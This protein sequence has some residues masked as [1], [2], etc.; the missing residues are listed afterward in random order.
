M[1]KSKKIERMRRMLTVGVA[2]LASLVMLPFAKAVEKPDYRLDD[3]KPISFTINVAETGDYAISL[4]LNPTRKLDGTYSDYIIRVNG[5]KEYLI[6]GLR[7]GGWQTANLDDAYVL[8]NKGINEIELFSKTEDESP[9]LEYICYVKKNSR[10]YS[11]HLN[12]ENYRKLVEDIRSGADLELE[13]NNCD[14]PKMKPVNWHG[15][16]ERLPIVYS[17]FYQRKYEKG[18]TIN[19]TGVGDKQFYIDVF[20]IGK[21]WL[22]QPSPL[23]ENNG[24]NRISIGPP[25][26]GDSLVPMKYI[27]NIIDP[28]TTDETQG[29]NWQARSEKALNSN[30]QICSMRIDI[31]QT[32]IYMVKL[33]SVNRGE[34]SLV[35]LT[36]NGSYV[37]EDCITTYQGVDCKIFAGNEYLLFTHRANVQDDPMLFVEGA[38]ADRVVAWNDD[39]TDDKK[40]AV[41]IRGYDAL[42]DIAYKYR[43]S[44]VHVSNFSSANPQSYVDL[45]TGLYT[46]IHNS[47]RRIL[48]SMTD[49]NGETDLTLTIYQGEVTV[50]GKPGEEIN[51]SSIT[52][53][54]C[55]I[56]TISEN[57]ISKVNL[58]PGMYIV[59]RVKDGGI[60][61]A[62]K[63]IIK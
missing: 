56:L 20:Y 44:R 63:I 28:C 7:Q 5:D 58:A 19:I 55:T 40:S 11:S 4:W 48:A 33:R 34:S 2:M 35:D 60:T 8:L 13:D 31:P 17:F 53:S 54:P 6:S 38:D 30:K 49:V 24:A 41:G 25:S 37:Y 43:T 61:E 57:G 29:L 50:E 15:D 14:S 12:S 22:P 10:N 51:I 26:L 59:S 32:G 18:Q 52:G 23:N 42:I 1:E 27:K 21:K 9:L 47:P 36:V 45:C 39:V 3:K 46:D 16:V 62:K